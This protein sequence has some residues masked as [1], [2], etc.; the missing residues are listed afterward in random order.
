VIGW[1]IVALGVSVPSAMT[2]LQLSTAALGIRSKA[3]PPRGQAGPSDRKWGTAKWPVL[4]SR[5]VAPLLSF[6][7]SGF[8][9]EPK[10]KAVVICGLAGWGLSALVH[11][12]LLALQAHRDLQ[13][14]T[15][16]LNQRN[17]RDKP[18]GIG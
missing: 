5:T 4:V 2:L 9:F 3:F 10:W 13:R 16:M 7:G 18:P 17:R 11:E 15:I 1:A 14:F 8:L 6:V 12:L